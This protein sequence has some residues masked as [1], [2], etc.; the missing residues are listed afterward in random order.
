MHHLC[1]LLALLAS[2][3]AQL[4]SSFRG[5]VTDPAGAVIAGAVIRLRGPAREQRDTTD[6]TGQYVFPSLQAGRYQ[7]HITAKGFS[8]AQKKDFDLQHPQIL[9]AQLAIHGEAQVIIVEDELRSVS[10]TPEANA[11]RVVLRERREGVCG[12]VHGDRAVH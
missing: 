1:L 9:D 2:A 4:A 12:A 10:A 6:H 5:T 11:S 3:S 7:V 8:A